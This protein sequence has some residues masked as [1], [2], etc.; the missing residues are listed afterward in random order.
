[1]Q[2]HKAGFFGEKDTFRNEDYFRSTHSLKVETVLFMFDLYFLSYI[3]YLLLP[4]YIWNYSATQFCCFA[5]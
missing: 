4:F 1:M 2:K 5:Y 3:L